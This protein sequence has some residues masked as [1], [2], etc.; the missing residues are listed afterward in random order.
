MIKYI[1]N[2]KFHILTAF[3]LKFYKNNNKRQ[4]GA[5]A[6]WKPKKVD[7]TIILEQTHR[8]CTLKGAEFLNITVNRCMLLRIHGYVNQ[9]SLFIKKSLL[10]YI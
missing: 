10:L 6:C 3:Y 1:E 7:L 9:I 5:F 2:V 8:D 4:K